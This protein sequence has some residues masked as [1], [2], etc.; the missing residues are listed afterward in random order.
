MSSIALNIVHSKFI[1]GACTACIFSKLKWH[2]DN[3][4]WNHVSLTVF[5]L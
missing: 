4:L 2:I 3:D 5:E 1:H